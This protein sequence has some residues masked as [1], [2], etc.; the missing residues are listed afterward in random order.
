MQK[1]ASLPPDALVNES[2]QSQTFLA[3]IK[4]ILM[5]SN[6]LGSHVKRNLNPNLG[7]LGLILHSRNNKDNR[8]KKKNH[9]CSSSW[10]AL[11]FQ[12]VFPTSPHAFCQQQQPWLLLVTWLKC[13]FSLSFTQPAMA[14][15]LYKPTCVYFLTTSTGLR[16]P[17][18]SYNSVI[19]G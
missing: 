8:D 6:V 11:V 3:W 14:L 9:L 17:M 19:Y 5:M 10:F 18:L 15:L 7:G 12:H 2:D 4:Q 16:S 1:W 13:G